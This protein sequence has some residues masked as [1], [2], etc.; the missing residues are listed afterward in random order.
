M[1]SADGAVY[2]GQ[3][4]DNER[5][6][7]GRKTWPS[8]AWYEGEWQKG[9]IEGE[10]IFDSG[11]EEAATLVFTPRRECVGRALLAVSS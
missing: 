4:E 11:V 9:N 8:G 1:T 3:W 2:I 10:G 6:G 7:S 5:H